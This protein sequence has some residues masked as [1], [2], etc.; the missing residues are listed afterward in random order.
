MTAQNA[1]YGL[2][3]RTTDGFDGP[4]SVC[5]ADPV[6]NLKV[7]RPTSFDVAEVFDL[8]AQCKPLDENSMYSNL[9]Q[10]RPPFESDDHWGGCYLSEHL[11][12]IG[13]VQAPAP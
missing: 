10:C 4:A 5:K 13:P 11:W 3:Q 9:L 12:N 1:R 2:L 7:S 6:G 8:I